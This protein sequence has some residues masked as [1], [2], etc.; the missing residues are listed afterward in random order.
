MQ[1]QIPAVTELLF[2]AV[3]ISEVFGIN[4]A[5]ISGWSVNEAEIE[6]ILR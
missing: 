5:I 2:Y 4:F 6:G 3:A 1:V